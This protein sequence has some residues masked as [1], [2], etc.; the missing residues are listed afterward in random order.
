MTKTHL[1]IEGE[2][3]LINGN[4]TYSEIDGTKPGAPWSAHERPIYPGHF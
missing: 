2:K 1:T 3:F 4:L